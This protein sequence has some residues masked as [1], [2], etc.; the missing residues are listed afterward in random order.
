MAVALEL[1][2]KYVDIA[3]DQ[4]F[5]YQTNVQNHAEQHRQ[6]FGVVVV[7]VVVNYQNLQTDFDIEVAVAAECP[8][9]EKVV[10]DDRTFDFVH[11]FDVA[12]P[13]DVVALVAAYRSPSDNLAVFAYFHHLILR[14]IVAAAA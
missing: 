10:A 5:H 1:S 9:L 8:V 11:N 13:V 12:S 2:V 14:M 3:S 4:L 7:V 6:Y